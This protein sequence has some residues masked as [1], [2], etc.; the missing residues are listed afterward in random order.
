MGLG[1][2]RVFVC[3]LNDDDKQI[4]GYFYLKEQTV[5]YIKII[6]GENTLTIPYHRLIK[7]KE[8][9]NG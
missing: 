1:I 6:S 7:L 5:N 3:Y 4:N 2:R 9:N 8:F